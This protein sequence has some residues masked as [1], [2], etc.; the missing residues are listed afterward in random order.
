MT[1][2]A[3]DHTTLHVLPQLCSPLQL[4]AVHAVGQVRW[5]RRYVW[6]WIAT[7]AG[8]PERFGWL[9]AARGSVEGIAGAIVQGPSR[10][11]GVV[12]LNEPM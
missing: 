3:T 2:P 1:L 10:D 4:G 6:A 11:G 12:C 7:H 5:G 8:S 9:W